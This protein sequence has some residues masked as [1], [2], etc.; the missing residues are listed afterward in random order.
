[1]YYNLKKLALCYYYNDSIIENE[2]KFNNMIESSKI[3][4]GRYMTI[5]NYLESLPK[6][7]EYLVD[8]FKSKS[9]LLVLSNS[10]FNFKEFRELDDNQCLYVYV[11]LFIIFLN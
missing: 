2:T 3:A 11:I 10:E 1:M 9:L 6:T 4:L 5:I 8:T 7:W